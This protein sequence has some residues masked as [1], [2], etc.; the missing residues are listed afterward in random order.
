[1]NLQFACIS[2]FLT[3]EGTEDT[4]K[5]IDAAIARGYK[6]C[7]HPAI[8]VCFLKQLCVSDDQIIHQVNH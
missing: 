2:A 8:K 7:A 5:T 3:L 4:V 1:M 6:I